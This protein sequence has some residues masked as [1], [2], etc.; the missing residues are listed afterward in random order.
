MSD[1]FDFKEES[2]F[3]YFDSTP[4]KVNFKT[5][6]GFKHNLK[7]Y[8][9]E[10]KENCKDILFLTEF[11]DFA[12]SKKSLIRWLHDEGF[13]NF[14]LAPAIR[15]QPAQ[16]RIRNPASAIYKN[17]D[18]SKYIPGYNEF[19]IIVPIGRAL[20]AVTKDSFIKSWRDFSEIIFGRTYFIDN[21]GRKV[22]PLPHFKIEINNDD[23]AIDFDSYEF[24]FSQVQIAFISYE[25]EHFARLRRTP[26]PEVVILKTEEEVK[27]FFIK[28]KGN[29]FALDSETTGFDS[30]KD[31]II[32]ITISY[33]FNK[34][35]FIDWKL[36]NEENKKL[37]NDCF[38]SG[39]KYY[40]NNAKFDLKF[41]RYNGISDAIGNEDNT[42]AHHLINENRP[43]T[44]KFMA[45]EFTT[46][47][48]YSDELDDL[49]T[50][51]KFKNYKDIYEKFPDIFIKY[52]TY[53]AI[54]AKIVN[55]KLIEQ[56]KEQGLEKFYY[57]VM[58]PSI[59]TFVE[60][61]M[62]GINTDEKYMQDYVEKLK[63]DRIKLAEE[64]YA[65][66]GKRIEISSTKQ[67]SDVMAELK[68]PYLIDDKK[69]PMITK[70]G[71]YKLDKKVIGLYD[72]EKYPF[73]GKYT[74]YNHLSKLIN[75]LGDLS[76]LGEKSDRE[77]EKNSFFDEEELSEMNVD[78]ESEDDEVGFYKKIKNGI[79]YPEYNLTGTKTGRISS[80]GGINFQN[81]PKGKD[82]GGKDFRKIF[83]PRPGCVLYERDFSNAEVRM[84]AAISKDENLRRKIVEEKVDMHCYIAE[85]AYH[86]PYEE[87]Y[88]GY[89][90]KIDKYV[91]MRQFCKFVSFSVQYGSTKFGLAHLLK[92]TPDEAQVFIDAYFVAFPGVKEY[93]TK[94]R[95]FAIKYGYVENS[96]G[97]K[98]HLPALFEYNDALK[99]NN[100]EIKT[101]LNNAI[102]SP[103]QGDIGIL[104]LV[105]M[106][107]IRTEIKKR[108]LKSKIIAQVH[109]SI[110]LDVPI[111]EI[112]IMDQIT[113]E[114]MNYYYSFYGEIRMDSD[115]SWGIE[116]GFGKDTESWKKDKEELD[117]ELKLIAERNTLNGKRCPV[118]N[119]SHIFEGK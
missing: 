42:I 78:D 73:I 9:Y 87:I 114:I 80:S 2:C 105:S 104:A 18:C 67:V 16:G 118:Y 98:S 70:K 36:M 99:S 119:Y 13:N 68:I 75:Q 69:R 4:G 96:W 38:K 47:G 35:Y 117:K 85:K 94:N 40:Y 95:K 116:W 74:E 54:V 15:C 88:T 50:K 64:I 41:L 7:H 101:L 93:I 83:L 58:I 11:P 113:E 108:G 115:V 45:W 12:D 63:V 14:T 44:L 79:I 53:D 19:K 10:T 77:L 106:N 97:R 111:N 109:D 43:Q 6:F 30:W 91:K 57:E 20:F 1:F 5:G 84:L 8:I 112:I 23:Y 48:G 103:I 39:N 17:C 66:I 49:K 33:E 3:C 82:T 25:L 81:L 37:L 72:A 52:S 65:S 92:I 90:Q 26:T 110:L 32:C 31:E 86:I 29:D 100:E 107:K 102:N 71:E 28:L 46:L 22:F 55:S 24:R 62:E 51:Y 59:E 60:V 21:L 61:E 34:G 27:N 89:K 76:I 56:L